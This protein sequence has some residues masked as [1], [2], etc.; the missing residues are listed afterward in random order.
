MNALRRKLEKAVKDQGERPTCVAF[1][2]TTLHEHLISTAAQ[3]QAEIDLSE[4]FLYFRCKQRDGLLNSGGTTLRAAS[5]S[6]RLDGQCREDLHPYQRVNKLLSVPSVAAVHDARARTLGLMKPVGLTLDLIK[7]CLTQEAPVV[8][9]IEIFRTAWFAGSDGLVAMPRAG[10][11]AVGKHAIVIVDVEQEGS[12]EQIIFLN[13][14]GIGWGNAGMG[15]FSAT[16]FQQHCKEL[17]TA[18]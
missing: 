3:A 17:W 6:L 16:Y 13:S 14:W 12:E 7:E 15:K 1:A 2:V 4:E 11:K 10:E 18:V 5:E 9:A 8:A